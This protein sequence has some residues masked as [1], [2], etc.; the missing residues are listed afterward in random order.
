M[1]FGVVARADGGSRL[2]HAVSPPDYELKPN[3]VHGSLS[4]VQAWGAIAVNF[5]ARTFVEPVMEPVRWE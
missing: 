3:E 1:L 4:K 5:Q 2:R